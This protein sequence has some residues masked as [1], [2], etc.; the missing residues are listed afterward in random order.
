M[1][2]LCCLCQ[3]PKDTVAELTS[4]MCGC[5]FHAECMN[6]YCENKGLGTTTVE[7][8][9]CRRTMADVLQAENDAEG[10]THAILRS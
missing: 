6:S 3:D 2:G 9:L 10:Q 1:A 5:T 8:P 7:C 4:L